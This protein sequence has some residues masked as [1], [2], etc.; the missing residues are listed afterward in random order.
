MQPDLD[1][2]M[3][4]IERLM[5]DVYGVVRDNGA[6][7][8]E[9]GAS[10]EEA[11]Y[12]RNIARVTRSTKIVEIGFN[13]GFSSIAFLESAPE[14][15]VVSFELD[16]RHG[17][18]LA[19]QFVDERYPG[20]HELVIGNS[21]QTVPA[22]ARDHA[23]SFELAFVDGGHEYEVAVSDIRNAC[24]LVR[25][26]G[27]VVVDDLTPWHPWGA[28]PSLAWQE[29]IDDGLI[30]PLESFADG[31]IVDTIVEPADRAWAA[32]RTAGIIA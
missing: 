18:E 12:L 27:I 1:K 11:L 17:V 30:E 28:G 2:D 23:G 13:V 20:R 14:A 8:Y 26:G 24:L 22:Y 21:V 3:S 5:W 19:K 9:G 29:A 32:A 7:I 31:K 6:R 4:R 15:T 16:R 10:V 25:P